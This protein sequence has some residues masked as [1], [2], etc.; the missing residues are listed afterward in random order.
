MSQYVKR[1]FSTE[2]ADWYLMKA[3]WSVFRYKLQENF[4]WTCFNNNVSDQTVIKITLEN[5]VLISWK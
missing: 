2:N 4:Y 5:K 3:V 1:N